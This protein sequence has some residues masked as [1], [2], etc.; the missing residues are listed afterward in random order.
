MAVDCRECQQFDSCYYD[1]DE[2][3]TGFLPSSPQK[4]QREKQKA[5]ANE[6]LQ[7]YWV[8]KES[9]PSNYDRII[10]KT[11]EELAEY[12]APCACPPIRFNKNTGDI[13]CPANKKPSASGCK[14]CW[15][16][17]LRQEADDGIL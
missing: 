8:K 3:C 13:V 10:S 7:R 5:I 16:D 14:S 12:L 2:N 9:K 11:P 1:Y 4:L 15:L 6:R 17:W